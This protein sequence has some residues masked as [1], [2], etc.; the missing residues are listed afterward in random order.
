MSSV[1]V[2]IASDGTFSP[3]TL[4]VHQGDTVSWVADGADAVVCIDPA[5]YFGGDRFEIPNGQT[6]DLTVQC[7]P[8]GGFDFIVIVG[9]LSVSCEDGSRGTGVGRGDP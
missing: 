3:S 8:I 6:L 5:D 2:T 4:T 1:T 9:D 7:G